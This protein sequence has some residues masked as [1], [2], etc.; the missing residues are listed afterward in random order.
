M[1]RYD[2]EL[3][4]SSFMDMFMITSTVNDAIQRFSK[5]G[6]IDGQEWPSRWKELKA[7]LLASEKRY[8]QA[9]I[10]DV[11]V[12][13]GSVAGRILVTFSKEVPNGTAQVTVIGAEDEPDHGCGLQSL[14]ATTNEVLSMIDGAIV[15]WDIKSFKDNPKG[16]IV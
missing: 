13:A 3:T 15:G 8:H 9:R 7:Y 11:E 14:A 5:G 12:N 4:T 6:W 2:T 1:N 10:S 16:A